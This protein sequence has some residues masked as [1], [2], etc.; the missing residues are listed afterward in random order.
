MAF[1]GTFRSNSSVYRPLVIAGVVLSLSIGG[2]AIFRLT[3][4]REGPKFSHRLHVQDKGLN[5]TICHT[6]EFGGGLPGMPEKDACQV[7]HRDAAEKEMIAVYFDDWKL[8]RPPVGALDPELIFDHS[9][10]S[11]S[12]MEC[13]ACHGDVVASDHVTTEFGVSMGEC[14]DCHDTQGIAEDCS[15]CHTTVDRDWQPGNHSDA[16]IRFHGPIARAQTGEL[17]EN[18]SLCH[19]E[20]SCVQCHQVFEPESHNNF[21]RLRGHGMTASMD[22]MSCAACH[23]SD[24]CSRCHEQTTPLSHSGNFGSP[25]NTHCI[26]CHLPIQNEGCFTCHKATPSHDLAPPKPDDHFATMNCRQCHGAGVPLPHVD[27]GTDCNLCHR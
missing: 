1:L 3:Q 25:Q 21:W 19:T 4:P 2:C 26:G 17:Q 13:A 24:F 14:I 23:R 9:R 18:C 5:C 11:L 12:D 10:H 6:R 15:T 16:W 22:R 27:D 20:S 7:C 8:N